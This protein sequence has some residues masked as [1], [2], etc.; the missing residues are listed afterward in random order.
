MPNTPFVELKNISKYF[1]KVIGTMKGEKFTERTKKS[2]WSNESTGDGSTREVEEFIVHPNRFKSELGVGEAI[3]VI[4]HDA[5]SKAISIKFQK[6]DDLNV[7]PIE[8]EKKEPVKGL[9]SVEQRNSDSK[10]RKD[11]A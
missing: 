7:I 6:Y 5:G 3:M 2:F 11:A 4:P 9:T 10:E 8:S 1:A